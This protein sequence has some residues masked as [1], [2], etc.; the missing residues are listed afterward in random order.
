[1]GFKAASF[2]AILLGW[3]FCASAEEISASAGEA[4]TNAAPAVASAYFA[5]ANQV[6]YRLRHEDGTYREFQRELDGSPV[7]NGA[8]GW[9]AFIKGAGI[10]V[11]SPAAT[12]GGQATWVF[13]AGRLV[14]FAQGETDIRVPY[15]VE[16]EVLEGTDPPYMFG[17][18]TEA[19]LADARKKGSGARKS[20][21]IVKRMF[22]GKW[23]KSGRLRYPFNNPNENGFLYASLALLSLLGLCMKPK[24]VKVCSALL[25]IAFL[26]LLGLTASRGSFVATALGIAVVVAPN[27]KKVF[28][29]VWTWIAAGI[30]VVSAAVWFG[31]HESRLLTR[32]FKGGSSWSNEIRLDMWKTSPRMMLDAPSGW[33]A[34]NVGRAYIDWYEEFDHLTAPGSLMNDHLSKLARL[35]NFGRAAYV[36]TWTFLVFALAFWGWRRKNGVPCAMVVASAAAI[37]FNPLAVNRWL[38]FAPL[39][40]LLP[41]AADLA[42]NFRSIRWKCA[43]VSAGAGVVVAGLFFAAVHVLGLRVE[44]SVPVNVEGAAVCVN[45]EDAD[46]CILDDGHTIGDIFTCKEIRSAYVQYSD[47]PPVMYVRRVRDVPAGIGRLVIGGEMADEWMRRIAEDEKAREGL[48]GEVVFISPPFPPSAIPPPLFDACKVRYVTGEFNARYD[49]EFRDPPSW[50]DIVPGME[51]YVASWLRYVFENLESMK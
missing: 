51:L 43:G 24:A 50:V 33:K 2:A 29:S 23:N 17:S 5:P 6:F 1:M 20:N 15:D 14:R 4:G 48:P 16:R 41:V 40:A 47:L 25:S 31:T 45:G 39:A 42:V 36:F 46:I 32:G 49:A 3:T 27:A 26:A 9:R 21:A 7:M 44:V 12:K 13:K 18:E 37:W 10:T 38:W 30:V 19:Q 28:S 35:G 8:N 11:K 34:Y 22:A